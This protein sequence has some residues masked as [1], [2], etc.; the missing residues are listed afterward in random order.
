K[1]RPVDRSAAGKSASAF[2]A[3]MRSV[4]ATVARPKKAAIRAPEVAVFIVSSPLQPQGGPPKRNR[5][6]VPGCP[7]Y[8]PYRRDASRKGLASRPQFSG[9]AALRVHCV[10]LFRRLRNVKKR[11][12]PG[13]W[14]FQA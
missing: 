12:Q 1:R 6:P 10:S 14:V 7:E 5:C 4:T 2:F 8:P 11:L 13:Q 3:D 9:V